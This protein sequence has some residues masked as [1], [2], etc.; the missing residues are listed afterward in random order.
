MRSVSLICSGFPPQG[1]VQRDGF[2]PLKVATRLGVLHLPRQVCFLPQQ[3]RHLLPGNRLLPAHTGMLVTR[4]LQEWACLL[5]L[6]LPLATAQ[7]LLGWQTGEE[8]VLCSNAIRDLVREH[9]AALRQA[10]E[11]Q[12]AA[13]L[14]HPEP[15]RLQPVLVPRESPRR[16]AAWPKALNTAVE[17]ALAAEAPAPPP[18]VRPTDWERVLAVRREEGDAAPDGAVLARLGPTVRPDEVVATVDEVVVRQP[19]KK[20]FGELRT[21]RITTATGSRYLC[22]RGESFLRTLLLV[23]LVTVGPRRWLTLVADGGRWITAFFAALQ[24]RL[25]TSRLILDWYHLRKKCT[26]R[27]SRL[28]GEKAARKALRQQVCRALWRGKVDG[29]LTL[30]A[31]FRPQ[32]GPAAEG[33]LDELIEYLQRHEAA[34]PDY[35]ERRRERR[36]IGSGTVEKANDLLVARRQKRRGMHWNMETSEGLARLKVLLLNHEWEAY[37][38]QRQMPQLV[39]P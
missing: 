18:G 27:L 7:R 4:A 28:G 14:A 15:Q 35:G 30:L 8:Q 10:E 16:P 17:T 26:D 23:L 22:G 6:D 1:G 9:G 12:V 33:A 31:Q 25:P 37:W 24:E 13:L 38:H 39:A 2:R 29:A 3:G 20:T 5:A 19:A 36:Y 32:V 21:A 11:Q 34:V